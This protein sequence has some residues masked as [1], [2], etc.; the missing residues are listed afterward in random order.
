MARGREEREMRRF[1]ALLNTVLVV[2]LLLAACG[3]TPTEA[4]AEPP[5]PEPTEP[6]AEEPTE[7]PEVIPSLIAVPTGANLEEAFDIE[8]RGTF[9][10]PISDVDLGDG[11]TVNDFTRIDD[12]LIEANITVDYNAQLGSRDVT[13]TMD[14]HPEPLVK[15][16][17][18]TVFGVVYAAPGL[19]LTGEDFGDV[20][21]FIATF[22]DSPSII[23]SDPADVPDDSPLSRG[24]FR[25][26]VEGGPGYFE[27]ETTRFVGTEAGM[28]ALGVYYEEDGVRIEA[29]RFHLPVLTVPGGLATMNSV[30]EFTQEG[31]QRYD[32]SEAQESL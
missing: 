12:H 6:P 20:P 27:D 28:V 5:A 3:P 32:F 7:A 16:A 30:E 14:E 24:A 22:D 13:V 17:G 11:I 26:A 18:I 1:T 31:I 4:P 21:V 9:L 2:A 15:T 25:F 19:F 23:I 29:G 8:I 10:S